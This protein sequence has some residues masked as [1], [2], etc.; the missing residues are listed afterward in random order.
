M[1]TPHNSA[2]MGDF[3][4]TVLMPGDPLRAKF[5]AETFLTDPVLVNNVRGVQGYT[6]TWKGVKVSVMASGMGIPSIG[7]YSH[8][9]YTQYGVENILRVGSTGALQEDVQL[10]D[11]VLAM[12][13][14]TNS[15]YIHQFNIPGTFA[16]IADY[17]LLRTA[18]DIAEKAGERLKVGNVLS[19]DTFYN[20]DPTF[21]D[22]WKKM[23]V[24]AIE[25]EA[26]GLY[27]NAARLGKR[28]LAILTVSD[29]IY[30]GEALPPEDRQTTFTQMME[31]AL[32]TAVA[33]ENL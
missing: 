21:N 31:I 5:I 6:G 3:G 26:A 27:T 32:D 7:I 30:T 20:D 10:R 11:I 23:N 1:S 17:T 9:L 18:A 8:E 4:K 19:A 24:L 25:M 12:G 28:A 33:M 29:H 16:P 13:A 14:S 22:R 2:K 15:N